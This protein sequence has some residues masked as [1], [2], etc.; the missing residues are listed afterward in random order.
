MDANERATY[1]IIHQLFPIKTLRLMSASNGTLS[2]FFS[3][4]SPMHLI[5]YSSRLERTYLPRWG[6]PTEG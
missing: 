6:W 2:I 4:V 5:P 1:C 3:G